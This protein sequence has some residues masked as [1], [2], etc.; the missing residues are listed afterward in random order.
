MLIDWFT[1]LAQLVNFLILVWLLKRLLYR[2]ILNAIDARE[3]RIAGELA[4]A[5]SKMAEAIKER[6]E[7]QRKN[8]AFE[9]QRTQ[10]MSRATDEAG[11]ERQRLLDEARRDADSLSARRLETLRNEAHTL[12]QALGRRVREEV[13]AIA[14]KMLGDLADVG[15]EERMVAA[16]VRRLRELDAGEKAGLAAALKNASDPVRICSAFEL[17]AAQRTAIQQALDGILPAPVSVRFETNPRLV[18]GIELG[19]NGQKVAW[20][21]AGYLSSLENGV[22]DLL[23]AKITASSAA[24]AASPETKQP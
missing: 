1:V 24:V 12:N 2:P 14:R 17:P 19:A 6:D 18:S 20:S 23:K 21:I 3:K 11:A 8:A 15:L 7:F 9:Q 22:D 16:F 13:F 5:A 10:L 4:A